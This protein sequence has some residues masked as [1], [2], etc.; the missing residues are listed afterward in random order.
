MK[1][2]LK[3]S[4]SLI[5][6]GGMIQLFTACASGASVADEVE[7][8]PMPQLTPE[9]VVNI[10]LTAF[11]ENNESDDGIRIAY[12]FASPLNRK[13]AGPVERFGILLRTDPYISM[14]NSDSFETRIMG[15]DG[16]IAYVAVRVDSRNKS[17]SGYIFI[18]TRQ[19][20][21]E[22]DQC[23]MTDG[24]LPLRRPDNNAEFL[25]RVESSSI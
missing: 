1:V 10:Q 16:N 21:G 17:S 7:L 22:F 12:R 24:V 20:S 14:L 8:L 5:L 6:I 9:E 3:L 11:Q 25:E 18:L 2:Q 23:W 13:S 19:Q 15:N 4:I